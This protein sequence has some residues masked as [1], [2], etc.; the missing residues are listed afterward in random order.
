MSRKLTLGKET[1]QSLSEA[2]ATEAAGGALPPT[3]NRLCMSQP[4]MCESEFCT[5]QMGTHCMPCQ[6]DP[7]IIDPVCK[8]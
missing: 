4:P 2:N 8:Y 6:I 1:L 7:S 3:H 5:V